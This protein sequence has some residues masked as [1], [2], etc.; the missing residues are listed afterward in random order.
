MACFS[1]F[2]CLLRF[3]V[4]VPDKKECCYNE[5]KMLIEMVFG[6]NSNVRVV[7]IVV[8]VLLLISSG[9]SRRENT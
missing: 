9:Y 6:K 2:Y 5:R 7:V 3:L 4:F 8:V 1:H